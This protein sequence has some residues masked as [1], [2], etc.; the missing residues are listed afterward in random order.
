MSAMLVAVPF[1]KGRTRIY[2]KKG[3]VWSLVEHLIL[4]VLTRKVLTIGELATGFNLPRR[5]VTECLIRLMRVDWLHMAQSKG[6]PTFAA[7]LAGQRAADSDELPTAGR[8]VT[9]A[10][11]YY[12]DRVVGHVFR[13]RGLRTMDRDSIQKRYAGR[14]L[15]WI[16]PLRDELQFDVSEFANVMLEEDERL[17]HIDHPTE[18]WANKF[19]VVTVDHGTVK[20]LPEGDYPTL[21]QAILTEVARVA[22]S[23]EGPVRPRLPSATYTHRSAVPAV[24]L[25]GFD[26]S[27]LVLGGPAHLRVLEHVLRAAQSRVIIH[28]TFISE[29]KVL[30]LL[31]LLR[32]TVRRGVRIDILWGQDD[33]REGDRKSGAK[34]AYD[35][36][37]H[38]ELS[39]LDGLVIHPF[40]TKSHSKWLLADGEKEGTFGVVIGSC[41]WLSSGFFRAEAS[42]RLRDPAIIR[43]FMHLAADL[44]C[45]QSGIWNPLTNELL[46]LAGMVRPS[47]PSTSAGA[48]A[49][50]VVDAQHAHFVLKARDEAR[51]R[52]FLSSHRLG[53]SSWP[54]ILIPIIE[55][56]RLG[57]VRAEV[58][59]GRFDRIKRLAQSQWV[60]DAAAAGVNVVPALLEGLHAK[61]LVWDDNSLLISSL[62]WL[63]AHPT[64][65]RAAREIGVWIESPNI[66]STAITALTQ[67]SAT[68]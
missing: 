39:I 24:H 28:S 7:T 30:S 65:F 56:C 63:S 62:N 13:N 12:Y 46:Q 5:V 55:A 25:I 20:G 36:S 44:T 61:V 38:P 50:L 33:D 29:E 2:L 3:R 31:P 64:E 15:L 48:K 21:Q 41:N 18:N 26:I 6:E 59:F 49:S 8:S 23:P 67:P 32:D 53:P 17:L 22:Q 16:D 27:D 35:L 66:S 47:S 52:I 19:L 14:P 4:D 57:T 10:P 54:G 43:E 11:T 34:I 68:T 42:V 9:R 40:S 37:K 58:H 60:T 51:E 1:A 45:A